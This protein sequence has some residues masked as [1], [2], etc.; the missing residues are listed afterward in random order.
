MSLVRFLP[1][2]GHPLQ[3]LLLPW[4]P[5]FLQMVLVAPFSPQYPYHLKKMAFAS[6]GPQSPGP[7]IG[8]SLCLFTWCRTQLLLNLG[9]PAEMEK[10]QLRV[11]VRQEHLLRGIFVFSGSSS[12]G[13]AGTGAAGPE[14]ERAGVP[15]Y[16]CGLGF[17][18]QDIPS[19]QPLIHSTTLTYHFS[20]LPPH[21]C[22]PRHPSLHPTLHV[23]TN[24]LTS[25]H[26]PSHST[27]L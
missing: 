18:M 22:T 26:P 25:H 10:R 15:L 11:K 17:W 21:T 20:S 12:L 16:R 24:P 8:L 9:I 13:P 14:S 2:S 27:T 19:F 23:S 7:H 6:V 1:A 4:A 5:W 3:H